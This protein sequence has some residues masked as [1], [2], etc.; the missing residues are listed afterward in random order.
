MVIGPD[1]DSSQSCVSNYCQQKYFE[2]RPIDY[3]VKR[4]SEL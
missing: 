4:S 2:S 1:R 3:R